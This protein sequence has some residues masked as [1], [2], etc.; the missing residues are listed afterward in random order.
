MSTVDEI[1]AAIERLPTRQ[2]LEVA[3]WLDERRGMIATSEDLFQQLDEEEGEAVGK[4][5]LGE[6]CAAKSG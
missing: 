4:Q 2:M 6:E 1:E 3:S 5:S